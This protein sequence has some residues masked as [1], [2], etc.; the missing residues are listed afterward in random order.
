MKDI[1]YM[2][3]CAVRFNLSKGSKKVVNYKF[4][5]GDVNYDLLTLPLY[6]V[7]SYEHL[8]R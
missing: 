7:Q 2:K 5:D 1:K 3:K 6:L 4:E 8:L